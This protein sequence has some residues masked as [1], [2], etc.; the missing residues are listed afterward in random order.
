MRSMALKGLDRKNRSNWRILFAQTRRFLGKPLVAAQMIV[1]AFL[2]AISPASSA[3]ADIFP[4]KQL[5]TVIKEILK[6]K[7]LKTDKI[8]EAD[9]KDIFFLTANGKDIADLTGL[10]KCTN[11]HQV[12]LT[13]NKI[14]NVKPL[15]GLDKIQSLDLSDNKIT[16]VSPLAK[17][18]KLQYLQLEKNQVEKLDGLKDLKAMRSLYLSHNKIQSIAPLKGLEKLWTLEVAHNQISDLKHLAKLKWLSNLHLE[19]NK[20]KDVAPLEGMTELR[21][22]FLERNQI[23]DI[24]TLLKMAKKDA[25]GERRF[26]PYWRLYLS[27]NPL[28]DAGKKTH[29]AE[30]KKIGVRVELDDK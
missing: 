11:L 7:Q 12:Q 16:D 27:G 22:T 6:K 9:L 23:T 20:I 5:E 10:E 8:N 21:F 3:N 25:Q 4:D 30:L 13:G 26:A 28:N 17:L 29:V 14:K 19:D 15:A 24:A 1:A 18:G 2:L